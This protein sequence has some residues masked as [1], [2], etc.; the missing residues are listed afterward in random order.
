MKIKY[1]CMSLIGALT[2][3]GCQ[4][5]KENNIKDMNTLTFN[6]KQAACM[7]AIACNEAQ[8]DLVSLEST[9]HNGLEA[10]LTVSQIK[11]AL[12]LAQ[13]AG[14]VAACGRRQASEGRESAGG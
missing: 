1:L 4:D 8:G 14:R 6:E 3:V 10:D 13:C 9:I 11:E 7:S 5:S 2:I 12:S